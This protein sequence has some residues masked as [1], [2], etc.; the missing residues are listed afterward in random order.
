MFWE[1]P[2]GS[3]VCLQSLYGIH[4]CFFLNYLFLVE[5]YCLFISVIETYTFILRIMPIG[6]YSYLLLYNTILVYS[7]ATLMNIPAYGELHYLQYFLYIFLHWIPK[8]SWFFGWY[9]LLEPLYGNCW[10]TAGTSDWPPEA[11]TESAMRAQVKAIHLC[12]QKGWSQAPPLLDPIFGLTA[13]EEGSLPG[14]CSLWSFC[15]PTTLVSTFCIY[16]IL[17]FNMVILAG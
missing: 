11:S 15:E 14:G 8:F 7:Y 6:L 12:D 17:F 2:G 13:T 1:R 4:M 16:L 5:S 9:I 3:S 10:I